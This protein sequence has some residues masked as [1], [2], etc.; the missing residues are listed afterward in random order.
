MFNWTVVSG[1][2][3]APAAI[4]PAT[5]WQQVVAGR[6]GLMS[7]TAFPRLGL[8]AERSGFADQGAGAPGPPQ[9][10]PQL[11]GSTFQM[12]VPASTFC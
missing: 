3:H 6:H 2:A 1:R 5:D 4:F 9:S 10:G 8:P 11:R 7:Y 12:W